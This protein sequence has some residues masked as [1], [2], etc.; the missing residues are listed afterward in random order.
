[1][2]NM[3]TSSLQMVYAMQIVGLL[4]W[5]STNVTYIVKHLKPYTEG[6]WFLLMS[7]RGMEKLI[8]W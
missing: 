1:M 8:F 5:E 7:K 6:D 3:Q 2:M 4:L